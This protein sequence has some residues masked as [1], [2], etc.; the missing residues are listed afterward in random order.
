VGRA[1]LALLLLAAAEIYLLL[2]LG[3]ALGATATLGLLVAAAVIGYVAARAQGLGVLRRWRDAV[4]VG[5]APEEGLTDGFLVL[6]GGV[7]LAMPGVVSDVL[8]LLLL[9]PPVRRRVTARLRRR[10][11]AWV[12]PGWRPAPSKSAPSTCARGGRPI[13]TIGSRSTRTTSRTAR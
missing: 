8:G 4:A 2:R 1:L 5:A 10:A 13:R 6:L 7:L 11:A 3:Q 9:V 12:A